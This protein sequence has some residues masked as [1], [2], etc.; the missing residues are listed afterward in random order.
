MEFW[1]CRITEADARLVLKGFQEAMRAILDQPDAS[2][3]QALLITP[4]DKDNLRDQEP[5]FAQVDACVH[6]LFEEQA[7]RRPLAPAVHAWDGD[8]NFQGLDLLSTRLAQYLISLGASPE[9]RIA[10]CME[11]S[12]WAVV[13]ML[14]ILKAGATV[15]PLGIQQPLARIDAILHNIEAILILVDAQQAER[16]EPLHSPTRIINEPFV[17]NLP[18]FPNQQSCQAEPTNA[19]WVIFTSGSTGVPKGVV[20]SHSGLCTSMKAHGS[21]YGYESTSRHLQFSAHTF[22]AA[23][24][25]IFTTVIFG[26]CVCIPSEND[27]LGDLAG[28]INRMACNALFMTSTVARLVKPEQVPGVECVIFGGEALHPSV[29]EPWLKR[30]GNRCKL[31]NG[32]GPAESTI[33]AAISRPITRPEDAP[34]IG[35]PLSSRFWVVNPDDFHMLRPLG[36]SGELLIEGPQLARG[37]MNDKEKTTAAFVTDPRFLQDLGCKTTGRRMYRTGDLVRQNGDGSY[38]HLGRRDAQI[39]IRG[40]RVETEEIEYIISHHGLARDAVVYLMNSGPFRGQLI[41]ALSLRSF[42]AELYFTNGVDE[43]TITSATTADNMPTIR[44]HIE[45]LRQHLIQ[46]VMQYMVPWIWIP[47]S[48]M[49]VNASAKVD[50]AALG[51]WIADLS[52]E[53]AAKLQQAGQVTSEDEESETTGTAI[54]N[55]LRGIWAKALNLPFRRI[56]LKQSFLSVGGDSITAIQVVSA[57]RKARISVS[58]RQVL[59]SRSVTDLAQHVVACRDASVA[60]NSVPDG[61]FG[62]SPAQKMYFE[63]MA[64]E[65]TLG[66]SSSDTNDG[67]EHGFYQSVFLRLQRHVDAEVLARA[68]EA[69]V[70]KHSMLRA[71]FQRDIA[72]G[73]IWHQRV[74]GTVEGSYLFQTHQLMSNGETSIHQLAGLSQSSLHIQRGPV[75]AVDLFELPSRQVLFMTA[76]HLVVD[77]V[78]WRIIAQDIEQFVLAGTLASPTSSISFPA[79]CEKLQKH[80][81]EY[82]SAKP[83]GQLPFT[84]TA[85]NWPYWDLVPGEYR[86]IDKVSVTA[87]LDQD[88]ASQLFQHDANTVMRTEPVEVLLAGLLH[89]FSCTFPDREVPAVFNEGHGRE[90]WDDALDLSDT[91]GWFT[92]LTPIK[93]PVHKDD[94]LHTL[95]QV[96]DCRRRAQKGAMLTFASQYLGSG[97]QDRAANDGLMELVFNYHGRYQQMER[98]QGLFSFDEKLQNFENAGVGPTIKA[99]SALDV[100]VFF[101]ADGELKINIAFSKWASRQHDLERWAGVYIQTL[102][103]LVHRLQDSGAITT[104][105]DFPL[106][107]LSDDEFT[108]LDEICF[109]QAG[110]D[111]TGVEDVLPC[112]N[113]QQGILLSQL[114]S[115]ES[116]AYHIS[117]TCRIR[118]TETDAPETE[119]RKL[120]SAWQMVVESHTILRTVFIDP[121]MEQGNEKQKKREVSSSSFLQVVLRWYAAATAYAECDSIDDL[122]R[123]IATK[124]PLESHGKQPPHRMLIVRTRNDGALY[125]N[126]QI[127]HALVDA[128]SNTL[129]LEEWAKAYHALDSS[130]LPSLTEREN[131]ETPNLA[132]SQY[133]AFISYLQ[134]GTTSTTQRAREDVEYWASL[135]EDVEPCH[136]FSDPVEKSGLS[137]QSDL[138]A[139]AKRRVDSLTALKAFQDRHNVTISTIIQLAWGLVLATRMDRAKVCFGYLSSAR[140]MP[141]PG[142]DRLIGPM[143]HMMTGVVGINGDDNRSMTISEAIA[144]V[145][146]RHFRGLEHQHASLADIH[147]ALQLPPSQALFN[148]GISFQRKSQSA[149]ADGQASSLTLEPIRA[150]DPTEYDIVMQ[151]S[152]SDRELDITLVCSTPETAARKDGLMKHLCEVL[153]MLCTSNGD[154][155]LSD[156]NLLPKSDIS[157]LRAMC[158]QQ[159]LEPVEACI[160]DVIEHRAHR[161]PGKEA[162]SA[163]DG[164]LTYHELLTASGKVANHLARLGANR[165][166]MIGVCMN[167][168]KWAAVVMLA[169]LRANAVVVPFDALNSSRLETSIRDSRVSL[170]IADKNQAERLKTLSTPIFMVDA[171]IIESLTPGECPVSDGEPTSSAWVTYSVTD[172]GHEKSTVL[173]HAALCTN[174]KSQ[175]KALGLTEQTRQLQYAPYTSHISLLEVMTTLVH[176]GCVCIPSEQERTS[177]ITAF[178][179]DTGVNFLTL[180][181]AAS[182]IISP[183]DVPG[184]ASFVFSGAT[185][186]PSDMEPWIATGRV[187]VLRAYGLAEHAGLL[188]STQPLTVDDLTTLIGFPMAA[189][190][191]VTSLQ[192]PKKLVP[193]GT[194]GELLIEEP[195]FSGKQ[196]KENVESWNSSQITPCLGTEQQTSP[197]ASRMYRS[198]VLVRQEQD[199]SFTYLGRRDEQI[200]I[201]GRRI[202]RQEVEDCIIRHALARDAIL[203]LPG[204]GPLRGQ[205]T[206]V[207]TLSGSTKGLHQEED[208]RKPRPLDD[209]VCLA[210]VAELREHVSRYVAEDI[211]PTAWI[212]LSCMPTNNFEEV[213]RRS[214]LQWLGSLEDEA[215]RTFTDLVRDGTNITP[216]SEM[217]RQIQQ[218]V[219]SVLDVPLEN[220]HLERSFVSSGGDSVTAMQM[221][222]T[223]RGL[224]IVLSVQQVL[225]SKSLSKLAVEAKRADDSGNELSIVPDGPFHL[226]PVQQMFMSEIAP[227][228]LSAEGANRYNQSILL[229][230]ERDVAPD[231]MGRAL[232]TVVAKHAM[233]RARFE[234]EEDGVWRQR[235]EKHVAD[236]YR[237]QHRRVQNEEQVRNDVKHSQ[238]SLD[239]RRGPVFAA[240]LFELPDRQVLFMVAHHL[241][242]DLVSWRIIFHDLKTVIQEGTLSR[243]QS[244]AFPTWC[245]LLQ[246]RIRSMRD[247]AQHIDSSE[248]P[249]ALQFECPSSDWEYWGLKPGTYTQADQITTVSVLENDKAT[250]LFGAAN[251]AVGT[252]PIEILLAGLFISFRRVFTDRGLPVIFN[253]GHGREPWDDVDL[254]DTVGWFTTVSPLYVDTDSALGILETLQRTKD[255]RRRVKY[256]GLLHFSSRY[257]GAL[258]D[259]RREDHSPMEVMFNYLG[260][261]QEIGGTGSLFSFDPLQSLSNSP[262]ETSAVGPNARVQSAIDIPAMFLEDRRLKFEFRYSKRSRHHDRIQRWTV[263]YI[264]ALSEL[265]D[266]LVQQQQP[267]ITASD[268]PLA[269][270]S[271]PDLAW[272]KESRLKNLGITD[273]NLVED[274]LPCSPMQEGIL[275]GQLKDPSRYMIR[276]TVRLHAGKARLGSEE[277]KRLS[278]AWHQVISQH[279]I[280]RTIFSEAPPGSR[281]FLQIVLQPTTSLFSARVKFAECNTADDLT[282]CIAALGPLEQTGSNAPYRLTLVSTLDGKLYCH[283]DISHAL[284]DASSIEILVHDLLEEYRNPRPVGS[285]VSKSLY[286]TYI[287]Y[288][289]KHPKP[290]DL[291]YWCSLLQDAKPCRLQ[292]HNASGTPPDTSERITAKACI[293][294]LSSLKRFRDAHNVTTATLFQLAWSLVLATQTGNASQSCFGYLSSGRDVPI[295]DSHSLVGPMINM[296]ICYLQIH[297]AMTVAEAVRVIQETFFRGFEHQRT[298]LAEVHHALNL[299]DQALFNTAM[300][301]RPKSSTSCNRMLA[302]KEDGVYMETI[303]SE[304]PTDYDF[305]LAIRAGENDIDVDL[306]CSAGMSTAERA[307]ALVNQ[308]V[309]TVEILCSC[310][311]TTQ[312]K[313]LDFL[314]NS[315]SVA[316]RTMGNLT[317]APVEACVH[318]LVLHEASRQPHA[319]ALDA[320]DGNFTYA[321]FVQLSTRLAAYI[322]TVI[323]GSGGESKI[324]ICMNKSKWA[325]VAMMAVLQAGGVVVPLGVQS[326]LTR[327]QTILQDTQASL[328][329]V[330]EKQERYLEPLS[331]K[332]LRV[333]QATIDTPAMKMAKPLPPVSHKNAAWV[334]YTSGSTGVPKGVVLEHGAIATAIRSHGSK[335]SSLDLSPRTRHLQFAAHTFDIVIRDIFSTL[336][337]GG[338][339]CIPSEA[340]RMDDISAAMRR[341]SVNSA[342]LTSTVAGLISPKDIPSLQALTLT[343]EA[344]NP[345]V[346]ENWLA[347]VKLLTAYGPSE[348]SVHSSISAPVRSKYDSPLIGKPLACRFWVASLDSP[349]WLVPTGVAGELLIEG[350]RLA[351]EYLNDLSKTESSFLINPGFVH[352]LGLATSQKKRFYRSGDIV[353][354]NGNGSFTYLGRR[355]TQIKIRGQRVETGEIEAEIVTMLNGASMA[356]VHLVQQPEPPN[357]PLLVAVVQMQVAD[358]PDDNWQVI[359]SEEQDLDT[360]SSAQLDSAFMAAKESL[361][362]RLPMYMVP[363]A[364]IA[365]PRLPLNASGKLDRK[366][367]QGFLDGMTSA[368]IKDLMSSASTNVDKEDQPR[369][370]TEQTLQRLWSSVLGRSVHSIGTSDNFFHIGGDSVLAMRMVAMSLAQDVRLSVVDIFKYPRLSDL[371]ATIAAKETRIGPRLVAHSDPIPF[372]LWQN[373]LKD[374]DESAET[375]SSLAQQ[376][377]VLPTQVEDV[378]PCTPLQEGLMSI[379]SHRPE[380][381]IVQRVFKLHESLNLSHLKE[382]LDHL[383]SSLTILRTRIIPDSRIGSSTSSVQVVIKERID[384]ISTFDLCL[385]DFLGRDKS[386]PMNYGQPL[387]RWATIEEPTVSKSRYLVWTAHHS[388]YDGWSATKILQHLPNILRGERLSNMIP[389]CRFIQYLEQHDDT[390][391]KA[392]WRDQFDSSTATAFPQVPKGHQPQPSS[393]LHREMQAPKRPGVIT[394]ALVLRAAWALLVALRTG[395]DDVVV[396]VTD[397]GRNVAVDGIES[398]IAPTI[399]TMPV[400]VRIQKQTT[401]RHLLSAVQEQAVVM[402]PFAHTG[403]QNIRRAVPALGEAEVDSCHLLTIQS[404]TERSLSQAALS[405][406][407]LESIETRSAGFLNYALHLECITGLESNAMIAIE[408]MYD[409][410]VISTPEAEGL[411]DQ[412]EHLCQ[413]LLRYNEETLQDEWLSHQIKDIGLSQN[414]MVSL[415]AWSDA[416]LPTANICIHELVA[417][418]ALQYPQATAI[419]AWDGAL[420]YKEL[421]EASKCL[422]Q[423]LISLGAAPG[424]KIGLSMDKS[425]WAPISMLA[426]LQAGAVVVPFSVQAPLSRLRIMLDDT[427]AKFI[428]T[429]ANQATRLKALGTATLEVCGPLIHALQLPT[430]SP[431]SL[432]PADPASVAWVLYTSGSTGTPKGV[433]LTNSALS[434]SI[435]AHGSAFGLDEKTRQLQFAEH[436]FDAMIEEVFTTLCHGGCVCIPSEHGRLNNLV[437]FM[438][439]TSVNTAFLTPTVA[440]IIPPASVPTVKTL[441]LIGEAAKPDVV[442]SWLPNATVFNGYGPSECSILSTTAPI[443]DV[444][445]A[446]NIGRSLAGCCWVVDADDTNKLVP[447]G[448]PGELLIEG[449]LLSEGYL[450]DQA[451]TAASFITD[452]DFVHLFKSPDTTKPRRMYRTGDLVTQKRDGSFVYLGRRDAQIKIR[453]QR[454]ETG[455]V[456]TWIRRLLPDT[457]KASVHLIK[458]TK[459]EPMLAAAIELNSLYDQLSTSSN[460]KVEPMHVDSHLTHELREL[461]SKLKDHLP[462]YMVPSFIV[463]FTRL[464]VN[465]SGKLDRKT[466]QQ[467]LQDMTPDQFDALVDTAKQAPSTAMEETVQQLWAMALG[468]SKDEVG[469]NDHFFYSGGDSISAMRMVVA[470]QGHTPPLSLA[471]MDIFSHPRLSDL[472][473]AMTEKISDTTAKV[474]STD[475]DP[476]PFTLLDPAFEYEDGKLLDVA[477]LCGLHLEEVKDAYP[478]TPLQEG[479]MSITTQRPESYVSQRVFKLDANLQLERFTA[480]WD[481]LVLSTPILRTRIVPHAKFG[482]IQV[483]TSQG[484]QWS[485]SHETLEQY[486]KLDKAQAMTYGQPLC[487]LSIIEPR[488]ESPN[489]YFVW[490]MHH[491]IYDGWS[492]PKML[493]SVAGIMKGKEHT[494]LPRISMARFVQYL[495]Q[496]DEPSPT[497]FWQEQLG[498]AQFS[499]FPSLPYPSYKP[500]PLQNAKRSIVLKGAVVSS[501][502]TPTMLRAAWAV[503]VST[504]TASEDV[505]LNVVSSG[506]NAPV[507][508]LMDMLGPTVTSYPVRVRVD[509]QQ[510]VL[511]FLDNLHT[512]A[513][514]II[515]FEHTGVQ[516]I[517]RMVPAL[518]DAS[519]RDPFGHMFVVQTTMEAL[520]WTGGPES[521]NPLDHM[522]MTSQESSASGFYSHGFNLSCTIGSNSITLEAWYDELVISNTRANAVLEQLDHVFQSMLDATQGYSA[523]NTKQLPTTIG[524]ID[525][526]TKHNLELIRKQKENLPAGI[527]ACLHSSFLEIA[528]RRPHAPAIH[529]WDGMLTYQELAQ[530]SGRL[531]QHLITSKA[532]K[533]EAMVAVRMTKSRWAI[534]AMLA[535]LRSG[536]VVVPL[537]LHLPEERTRTI[538]RD[539]ATTLMLTDESQPPHTPLVD[540]NVQLLQVNAELCRS[541]PELSTADMVSQ[542]LETSPNSAAWV[543][544]TSGSTGVPKGVVLTHG[545]LA[546]SLHAHGEAFDVGP[547]TRQFQ[548]AS[549]TFDVSIQEIFTTLCYAGGCVCVP[550]EQER[551]ANLADCIRQLGA[552]TLTLTSTVAKLLSPAEVP[553]VHTLVLT[554][555]PVAADVV[556]T[557]RENN[558]VARETRV[559]NAYGPAECTIFASTKELQTKEEASVIGFPLGSRFWVTK[560]NNPNQLVPQGAPGELLIEGP[561]VAKYYLNNVKGTAKAFITDPTFIQALGFE[562]GHRMYRTGDLV[563]ENEDDCFTYLGRRDTQIKIH[564]QRVELG[565]IEAAIAPLVAKTN[566][567]SVSVVCGNDLKPPERT[568][569]CAMELS[570]HSSAGRSPRDVLVLECTTAMQQQFQ[571]LRHSL[572]DLLPSYMVP[573]LYVPVSHIPLTTSYKVDRL[574][575]TKLFESLDAKQW[576]Q[577]TLGNTET[578]AAPETMIEKG[579]RPVWSSILRVHESSIDRHADFFRMGGDSILSMQLVAQLKKKGYKLTVPEVFNNPKL[580]QMALRIVVEV[581]EHYLVSDYKPFS[582][583]K[584][585]LSGDVGESLPSDIYQ[586]LG[587]TGHDDIVDALPATDFQAYSI[588]GNLMDTRME[589][590]HFVWTARGPPP[591]LSSLREAFRRLTHEI[592]SLRTAFV[593]IDDLFHQVILRQYDPE[594]RVYDTDQQ[595]VEK[596]LGSLMSTQDI[597]GSVRPGK[598]PFD[599]AIVHN[600]ATNQHCLVFRMSHALYD[601]LALPMIWSGL[602]ACYNDPNAEQQVVQHPPFRHFVSALNAGSLR[603]DSK[604]Y[605]RNLL[606]GATMPQIGSIPPLKRTQTSATKSL[607]G[608]QFTWSGEHSSSFTANMVLKA[609]WALVLATHTNNNDVSFAEVTSGRSSVP[610][611]VANTPGCCVAAAPVR[612][613]MDHATTGDLLYRVRDQQLASIDHQ[614]LGLETILRDCTDWHSNTRKFSSYLNHQRADTAPTAARMTLGET[615]YHLSILNNGEVHTFVDVYIASVQRADHVDVSMIY[616]ADSVSQQTAEHLLSSLMRNV[617]AVLQAVPGVTSGKV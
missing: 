476:L 219:G 366:R 477:E 426:I 333:N 76:H 592:E 231:K 288:L 17:Q 81:T 462:T 584:A 520:D 415:R 388:V 580:S 443:R 591:D 339:V 276:S 188:S 204:F 32:Y 42:L 414:D 278:H 397:S 116:K 305:V 527:S 399:T 180:T 465:S 494:V 159:P 22:D 376:C 451:K 259:H 541:L 468:C 489:R 91:V 149:D 253:E 365:T 408:G 14:A 389:V 260:R 446:S 412:F 347:H 135:L 33:V 49:P 384:W 237:F 606:L 330:D 572:L 280:M 273:M 514:R 587:A 109:A 92:I 161:Q 472:A 578:V 600:R 66:D 508:G 433:V 68:V 378:Y 172:E 226:S 444:A 181:S 609:A 496:R 171:E 564:G 458:Q 105:S 502:T 251:K 318:D 537:G 372:S 126:L 605:W 239:L 303:A 264:E 165:E 395:S 447:I 341:M 138:P 406:A 283:L 604:A 373:R 307:D 56:G 123:C 595:S 452:P 481:A 179:N 157:R 3:W 90:T 487:R 504:Y 490:T 168:S 461:Q 38:T 602:E 352:S 313:H 484:L 65:S 343:G 252:E 611:T 387:S 59:Q 492:L 569:V 326:P 88:T 170:V 361:A 117:L 404:S 548:F 593:L 176:G 407:G 289:Q 485:S 39:K 270:L 279:S 185:V 118:L 559:F 561:L 25:E 248:D 236:S 467:L 353:R 10:V 413:I 218:V 293:E 563:V 498:D 104:A 193:I 549:F 242:I 302:S 523:I 532:I 486:L 323:A 51:S 453:G 364:I 224:G 360:I 435:L 129:L 247:V 262:L 94:V 434:T 488:D 192:H 232:R 586:L 445:A 470:A 325:V 67:Q 345:S 566:K 191:W 220:V 154:V 429:D 336:V 50:R 119:V 491:S 421:L 136:L 417:Q 31:Y 89:S 362:Q 382:A 13:A 327:I 156:L 146:D 553:L 526:M 20:L 560:P 58:V 98:T 173:Q 398:L 216:T 507:V 15:V 11:K 358:K 182:R 519:T 24:Q 174:I 291:S 221:V 217:E 428:I 5:P 120:L 34:V 64:P 284:V 245:K 466:L 543:I 615:P 297:P 99:T 243:P 53:E 287:S 521:S 107:H 222:S 275:L 145:H 214:L 18:E 400:R 78:S 377:G 267:I 21:A 52:A 106:A 134:K 86:A 195:D 354:R 310:S 401:I 335:S 557:W 551:V 197:L 599:V 194:P 225:R 573:A 503:L 424:V 215:A 100:T 460:G 40:Q 207:L 208:T 576:Q 60:L 29:V 75:F 72:D 369:T 128:T 570:E 495:Q 469:A 403:L 437:T 163:W 571:R 457:A 28:V 455:E 175:G 167:K 607:D 115:P 459:D 538:I 111:L 425:V 70:A 386:R 256:R 73:K 381:Y 35:F 439:G 505:V 558:G 617:E 285:I 43:A 328:V 340:E 499:A 19:G 281:G 137:D 314:Q 160:H 235:I 84:L 355:D 177:G 265:V 238:W 608:V 596:A 410:A 110:V 189:R 530:L 158:E 61:L 501:V 438:A 62:L 132:K 121:L 550:Q 539:T 249:S 101:A 320:W 390:A 383:V 612:V 223:C 478:C 254:S 202:E 57:C 356:S 200:N 151:V 209:A 298:S 317:I 45:E 82:D 229:R 148:T 309:K 411:L 85:T 23:I 16:L 228:G 255:Q 190:F 69:V 301:Y 456:E 54:E 55:Q 324:G 536:A 199:E 418:R 334:N 122:E 211:L 206:I 184:V 594:I 482:V 547:Q 142:A 272:L 152:A 565:E 610:A 344:V 37:Y 127:S 292:A 515:P 581:D 210:Q 36:A 316:F 518:G 201:H 420:S 6:E 405:A 367:V 613:K 108:S 150:E 102:K 454:V 153:H 268:F 540:A 396:Y 351:R 463:P 198:G 531:A 205:L 95:R 141:I 448:A 133:S 513:T 112:S 166:V 522:G 319:P 574:R 422:A 579:I 436:T 269:S 597:F 169:I 475:R 440:G 391:R 9:V 512:Q 258:K 528:K 583:L 46:N 124:S 183:A 227:D 533:P 375:L 4:D 63:Y 306:V 534:V 87:S 178:I 585:H 41:V 441:V 590:Y 535:I 321:E 529:S 449:P 589:L 299:S 162:V 71:R 296:M 409:Q 234:E 359:H 598:P 213:D 493:Q 164:S 8:L 416:R 80:V 246:D 474:N 525:L 442:E 331:W 12:L 125:S 322:A 233:L 244:L 500:Q 271:G 577:L 616:A 554:G 240:I 431:P 196:V 286:S 555:E 450:G 144:N 266:L 402:I 483:V 282:S 26:G 350:P 304:N 374:S 47:I 562:P 97:G 300:T 113:I 143:L 203:L 427:K 93:V 261:Y 380:A 250:L 295:A 277:R 511:E 1:T 349:D 274:I 140:H 419:Q 371:A 131:L 542:Q 614:G 393:R 230:L 432:P 48:S 556:E 379:T 394:T 510:D 568:L 290:I 212:P 187:R 342:T 332:T 155:L 103:E 544:Y 480:A 348:C 257:L 30:P 363:K 506:R 582:L 567:I 114:K 524:D 575:L 329:L 601:G 368:Q 473:Q 241:I 517:R 464:P 588:A 130:P 77:L 337:H 294:D 471:V 423:R 315:D 186:Y 312:L 308:F 44:I 7:V 96:K 357:E 516:N 2:V 392:F 370:A 546:S 311:Q 346:V 83:V 147:H 479:L 497:S 552:N 263:A 79:W 27:R 545:S 139:A 509:S 430:S 385:A 338:C 74:D 603:L